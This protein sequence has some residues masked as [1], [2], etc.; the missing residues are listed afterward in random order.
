MKSS[1]LDTHEIYRCPIFKW[2]AD[3]QWLDK[4]IGYK[5]HGFSNSNMPYNMSTRNVT[6]YFIT[7]QLR[8][9]LSLCSIS[10]YQWISARLQYIQ[11]VS[12]GAGLG[13][14]PD[15][16]VRVQVRVLA[17]CVSTS[18]SLS[19]WLLHEYESESEYWLMSTSTGIWSTFY[20]KSSIAFFSL[21]RGNPQILINLRQS[22]NFP[23]SMQIPFVNIYLFNYS[24]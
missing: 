5:Y 13:R 16:R 21:W 20:T 10:I 8:F 6:H 9:L 11:C 12:N 2:N 7:W 15:L 23:L 22:Y 3:L 4:K 18:T 1:K 17:I 24:M 19:T 14:V